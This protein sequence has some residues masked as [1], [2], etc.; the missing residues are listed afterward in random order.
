MK[1]ASLICAALLLSACG[2]SSY[3]DYP[4]P[5]P[6]PPPVVTPPV[7]TPP[8]PVADAYF[9]TVKTAVAAMPDDAEPV[10]IDAAVATM[11]EDTEPGEV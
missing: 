10:S 1:R 4:T 2:G 6:V 7:V 9:T 8:A 3:N 11:P 5:A